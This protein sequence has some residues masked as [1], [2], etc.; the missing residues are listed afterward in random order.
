MLGIS[1]EAY[2]LSNGLPLSGT[3]IGLKIG[4]TFR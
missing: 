1:Y 2:Q 4:G 3:S